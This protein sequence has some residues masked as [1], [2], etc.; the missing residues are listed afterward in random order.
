M[1]YSFEQRGSLYL[2]SFR[3]YLTKDGQYISPF[4]DIPLYADGGEGGLALNMVVEVLRYTNAKMEINKELKLNPI[5]QDVKK[6]LFLFKV[7][8]IK[9]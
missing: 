1:T 3:L 5:K 8:G 2:D 6:V 9:F 7:I 4:H